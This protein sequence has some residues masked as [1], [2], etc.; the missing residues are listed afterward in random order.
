MKVWGFRGPFGAWIAI[1]G[2]L[3]MLVSAPFDNW[4]HDAYGLD[5]KI[6]SPPHSV[7]AI[8]MWAVAW[9]ALL[10]VLREQNN[11]RSGGVSVD[12]WL[13]LLVSGFSWPW[14]LFS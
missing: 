3:A 1:W 11:S 13:Y 7:L 8:G 14:G 4:W 10:L 12:G 6:L 5:V 2:S 9:G